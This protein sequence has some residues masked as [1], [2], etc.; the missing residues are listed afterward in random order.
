[1]S[2]KCYLGKIIS[3]KLNGDMYSIKTSIGTYSINKSEL[4]SD[5]NM[6]NTSGVWLISINNQAYELEVL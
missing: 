2:W 1:M 6:L 3:Y 4:Q 5:S